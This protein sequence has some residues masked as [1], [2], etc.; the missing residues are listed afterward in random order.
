[1]SDHYIVSLP[2]Q[3]EADSPENAV[4]EFMEQVLS[5]GLRGWN[6]NLFKVDEDGGV[7]QQ[8]TVK[9]ASGEVVIHGDTEDEPVAPDVEPSDKGSTPTS[10]G[11]DS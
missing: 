7:L 8:I 11:G 3:V 5:F 2:M 10:D 6:F 4:E 9:G 1:M